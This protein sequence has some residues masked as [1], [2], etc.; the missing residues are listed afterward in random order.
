MPYDPMFKPSW[1][2]IKWKYVHICTD[3]ALWSRDA[4][5]LRTLDAAYMAR[6]TRVPR[7]DVSRYK[8]DCSRYS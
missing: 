6:K 8:Y 3:P 2:V 4:R 7:A 1:W 5:D